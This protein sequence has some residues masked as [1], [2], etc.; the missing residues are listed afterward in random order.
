[1]SWT[2][3]AYGTLVATSLLGGASIFHGVYRATVQAID[4]AKVVDRVNECSAAAGD[5]NWSTNAAMAGWGEGYQ[6]NVSGAFRWSF[7]DFRL[8]GPPVVR[9]IPLIGGSAPAR[10]VN[11][12]LRQIQ[13]LAPSFVQDVTNG[14]GGFP[15]PKYWAVTS[16]WQSCQ[17]GD[18]TSLWTIAHSTNGPVFGSQVGTD[19]S[20]STLWEAWR[21]LSAFTATVRQVSFQTATDTTAVATYGTNF[22][23]LA[24][25]WTTHPL[26]LD[27]LPG[28]P[29]NFGAP[30]SALDYPLVLSNSTYS[31]SEVGTFGVGQASVSE[32]GG[33]RCRF[34]TELEAECRRIVSYTNGFDEAQIHDRSFF[35][36]TDGST[37]KI[38]LTRTEAIYPFIIPGF[39]SGVV[40]S[41]TAYFGVSGRWS[42][43]YPRWDETNGVTFY[44]LSTNFLVSGIETQRFEVAFDREL[45]IAPSNIAIRISPAVTNW[46]PEELLSFEVE[47]HVVYPTAWNYVGYP[48]AWLTYYFNSVPASS[49]TTNGG[50]VTV[51]TPE[52]EG[53]VLEDFRRLVLINWKF[54]S[55]EE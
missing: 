27:P 41:V 35:K 36:T 45:S 13:A 43:N 38:T 20:T 28:L 32:I 49:F 34:H 15:A 55:Q 14:A 44:G 17:I 10:A 16:L 12:S 50:T 29:V 47:K 22:W 3:M 48:A 7:M 51:A 24:E 8:E 53:E 31:I 54:I 25:T 21:A 40:A 33:E 4:I 19:I 2:K 18:G 42:I 1:M 39:P 23:S 5:W 6:T 30:N 9:L 52:V 26:P 37:N 46:I 11:E